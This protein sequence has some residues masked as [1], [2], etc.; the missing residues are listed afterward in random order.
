MRKRAVLILAVGA[1]CFV[2]GTGVVVA[3]PPGGQGPGE[4]P[5]PEPAP[6]SP[7]DDDGGDDDDDGGD[8]DDD[9]GDDDDDEVVPV[10]PPVIVMQDNSDVVEALERIE[11]LLE[12][13]QAQPEPDTT[14]DALMVTV[15]CSRPSG[16]SHA[17]CTAVWGRGG[18]WTVTWT[19]ADGV[20][21]AQ[22]QNWNSAAFS[23][24]LDPNLDRQARGYVSVQGTWQG[25]L[26]FGQAPWERPEAGAP[27]WSS[28]TAT[29]TTT[30]I[31]QA[32]TT[33][34]LVHSGQDGSTSAV[35]VG[36]EQIEDD[37]RLVR[38]AVEQGGVVMQRRLVALL[39]LTSALVALL[40]ARVWGAVAGHR[41]S[42]D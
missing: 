20:Q 38:G 31:P 36:L 29:T 18:A 7:T 6:E 9:G 17:H 41:R 27:V 39:T 11:V 28:T 8:D 32:T 35:L 5:T 10:T 12:A 15:T 19:G 37:V 33:T 1:A 34:M 22:H 25:A 13:A 16:A 26:Y 30:T 42:G 23:L 40:F 14:F 4:G 24:A 2:F 21:V 3:Q